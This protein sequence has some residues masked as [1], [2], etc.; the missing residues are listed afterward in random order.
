MANESGDMKLLGNYGALIDFVT[1]DPDYQPANPLIAK[2]ALA[3]HLT[4]SRTSFDDVAAAHSPYKVTVNE[5]Q[6][7][8]APVPRKVRGA[9]AMLRAGGAAKNLLDDAN[10]L[11]LKLTGG[12]K[13]PKVK[14]DPSTPG[15]ESAQQNSASQMSYDN[16]IG[17]LTAYISLLANTPSYAPNEA[18][19][20]VTALEALLADL[21]TSNKAVSTSYVVL[22]QARGV[23]DQMLYLA[24]D[25]VVNRALLVKDYVQAA[26]GRDSQIYKQIKGIA[27]RRSNK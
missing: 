7:K 14:D 21:D 8:F 17:N 13:V 15:D 22:S 24:E 12:R 4:A 23:R 10:T 9:R 3:A 25:S 19:L 1:A 20:K 16:Q 26:F 18:D 11:V 6:D 2:A 5:R 27:F